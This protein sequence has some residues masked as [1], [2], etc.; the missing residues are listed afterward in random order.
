MAEHELHSEQPMPLPNE[1]PDIQGL[2]IEDIRRRREVGIQR[3]GTALQPFNGRDALRDAY[4]EALDLTCYLRQ[5]IEERSAP[6]RSWY[7]VTQRLPKWGQRVRFWRDV[8]GSP[9]APAAPEF[10]RGW[11]RPDSAPAF[12]DETSG[13]AYRLW[14]RSRLNRDLM[15]PC[16]YAWEP[17]P[18]AP[19]LPEVACG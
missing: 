2:V 13:H 11:Y 6:A 5:V 14:E 8:S 3:Y 1:R 7:Y 9:D 19:P 12:L 10:S 16:V 17:E 15:L 4:E 18:E